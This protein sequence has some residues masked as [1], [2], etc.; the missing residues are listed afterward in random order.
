MEEAVAVSTAYSGLTLRPYRPGD[1]TKILELFRTVFHK[2]RSLAHW[3]WQ[4]RDN[5]EGQQVLVATTDEGDIVGQCAGIPVRAAIGD[6]TYTFSQMVDHM[7]H[8]RFR[9]G[10]KKPG[11]QITLFLAFF[12]EFM[13][14]GKCDLLYGF[15]IPEYE[16]LAS[17]LAGSRVL[18]S[19][20]TLVKDLP[21]SSGGSSPR[22]VRWHYQIRRVERFDSSVDGLWRRCKQNLPLAIIRDSRYLNWR[23]A[24]C[25]DRSYILLL[26]I[27][28]WDGAPKALAVLRQGIPGAPDAPITPLME[29]LVPTQDSDLAKALIAHC[30]SVAVAADR[31]QVQAWFPGYTQAHR[32]LRQLGYRQ[33]PTMYNLT[34]NFFNPEIAA[35]WVQS[36]WY[37]TMGD[38]D[39]F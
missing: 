6:Q 39:I 33:E 31:P 22:F 38:S 17:K 18:Q 16:R 26:V 3:Y 11:L 21:E 24:A 14:P 13:G 7:V 8:P 34:A 5:P 32:L 19:V 2:E 29:M 12:Q 36:H 25:P 23:Y 10:L 4:F 30:H 15:P 35:E 28:R 1:E 37:Y 20:T 9:R 27:D